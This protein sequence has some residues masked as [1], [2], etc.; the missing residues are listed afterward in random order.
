MYLFFISQ[1]Q[2]PKSH[3]FSKFLKFNVIYACRQADGSLYLKTV[4][5]TQ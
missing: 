4:A 2:G 5:G 3:T 1:C